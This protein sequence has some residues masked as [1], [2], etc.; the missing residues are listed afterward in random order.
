MGK[1]LEYVYKKMVELELVAVPSSWSSIIPAR[2]QSYNRIGKEFDL[3][4]QRKLPSPL[5]LEAMAEIF[6]SDSDDALE[7]FSSSICALMLC[8]PDRSIE[9]LY[10]PRDILTPDWVDKKTGEVGTGLRWYPAKGARPTVKTVIPSMRDIA[11]RAVEKLRQLSEPAQKLAEWY[12]KHHRIYLPPHLEYL[13]LNPRINQREINAIL[14]SGNIRKLET[15]ESARI[16]NW[17]DSNNVPRI[18]TKRG[19][20]VSFKDLERAVLKQL[21]AGFPIMDSETGMRYSEALCLARKGEFHALSIPSQCCFDKVSYGVLQRALKT[22]SPTKQ[23]VFERRGYMDKDRKYL[24]LSTHMLRHYL[25]TLVRHSGLLTEDE[26]AVW[27]GRM[28][29]RQ[30]TAYNH[31]SDRDVITKLRDAVG[32]PSRSVGPFSNIDNRIFIRRDE[33]ANIKIITAHT[34][35]LGYC[36]HD[37]AQ[38]PCQVHQDCINCNEVVCIKGDVRA[39]TNLRKMHLELTRLQA[40]AKA[41]FSA[42]V[43]NAAE[44]FAYQTKTLERVNQL[45]AILDDPEVPS[46]AVIQLSGVTPPS[47]LAMADEMRKIRIKP[48]SQS[49]TSLD[50]VRA[51]LT[52]SNMQNKGSSNDR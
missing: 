1:S 37:Y 29:V 38:S 48:V 15:N 52:D 7:I 8:S 47:R 10:A 43:L 49:I 41:A 50:E 34:T 6:N 26:I 46:G 22:S 16:M 13:R 14:F 44:W 40:D 33:F 20:S 19:S 18:S 42:E 51:L 21:P 39:E 17:L 27:S 30:N 3:E 32:D 36:I 9:M 2:A 45:L 11:V 5:A 31:E 24:Y 28:S 23:S 4:R 12:E 25:N 35:E